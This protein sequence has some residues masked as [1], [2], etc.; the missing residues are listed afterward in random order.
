MY[1]IV[2]ALVSVIVLF[3]SFKYVYKDNSMQN[4]PH[5]F[6]FSANST[7]MCSELT[8]MNLCLTCCL[9]L[10]YTSKWR[11]MRLICWIDI[12]SSMPM[13]FYDVRRMSFIGVFAV[14]SNILFFTERLC[15]NS[16][17]AHVQG[18]TKHDQNVCCG[19]VV[20]NV[21]KRSIY[22]C[23]IVWYDFNKTFYIHCYSE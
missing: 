8:N 23:C 2:L 11:H 15:I 19:V 9:I 17:A 3:L 14:L 4:L 20:Y 7:G 16:V 10:T 6:S 22:G 5:S 21:I 18:N 12:Y 1:T 13:F